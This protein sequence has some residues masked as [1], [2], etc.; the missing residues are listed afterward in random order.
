MSQL[1]LKQFHCSS[2]FVKTLKTNR[3]PLLKQIRKMRLKL[4]KLY[5]QARTYL[6]VIYLHPLACYIHTYVPDVCICL[7]MY[8]KLCCTYLAYM[9]VYM[10]KRFQSLR[11]NCNYFDI[12]DCWQPRQPTL[13]VASMSSVLLIRQKCNL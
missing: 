12:H 4:R 13:L 9:Y 5:Q 2:N 1:L 10:N 3:D 6:Q 11:M 7:K 8:C